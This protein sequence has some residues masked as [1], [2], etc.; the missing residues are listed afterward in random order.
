MYDMLYRSE[1]K[2]KALDHGKNTER[3]ARNKYEEVSG[4]Q[5]RLCGMFI[6]LEKP[7]LCASP[8]GLVGDDGLLEIKCPWSAHNLGLLPQEAVA[9]K[10]IAHSNYC[11]KS[12]PG[13]INEYEL[14]KNHAY[15]YQVQ[16]QLHIARKRYCLFVV[17]T[18]KGI[19][20]QK[21]MRDDMFRRQKMEEKLTKF[22]MNA[23]LPEIV[24]GWKVRNQPIR[25]PAYLKER[26]GKNVQLVPFSVF[27]LPVSS[28]L[29]I[30]SKGVLIFTEIEDIGKGMICHAPYRLVC[31][32]C[33]VL[34][35]QILHYTTVAV[36]TTKTY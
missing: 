28:S 31:Q 34:Q 10:R 1:I 6:D 16:G 29:L 15:Y 32:R 25:E 36:T 5:V 27:K 26:K 17:Y 2:I 9:D 19:F 14:K 21:V 20:I 13:T 12:V 30:L 35:V 4:K 18:Y 23:L 3:E 24:D 7:Y 11:P 8:Y 22:Y 33:T